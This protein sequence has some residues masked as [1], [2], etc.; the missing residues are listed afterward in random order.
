[1]KS[2]R[3]VP[4]AEEHLPAIL[5]IE[6]QSNG[7]PWSERSFRHELDH[8]HA[9]F[10]VALQEGKVVGY[11]GMWLIVDEAHITTIAITPEH[12]RQ[13]IGKRLM[14]EL[15]REAKQL[16]MICST[17]E[18]RSTNEAAIKLYEQ[19][20]YTTTAIRAA[21]YPDNREDANVMW[22]FNLQDWE[23]QTQ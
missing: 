3:F 18:V 16:G 9:R 22:L 17:L 23:P 10:F 20:G 14:I 12:R 15:L 4:L 19:L 13:G 8:S 21:Y 11:G 2:L 7:A 5:E 1:M 6:K